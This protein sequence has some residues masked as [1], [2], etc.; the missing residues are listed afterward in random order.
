MN[1]ISKLYLSRAENE[2]IAGKILN[3]VSINPTIQKEQFKIETSFTF[4][5][6]VISHSYY[7][8]FNTA[9]AILINEGIKTDM[10]NVHKKT[11]KAFK[12]F[13]V[14]TGKLDKELFRIYEDMAIKADVLLEIFSSEKGKRGRFTYQILPQANVQPAKE[15]LDN[16]DLFFKAIRK[17]LE[18]AK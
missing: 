13:L 2:L 16:A 18:E 4:Y 17:I 14:Q 3:E 9:K 12:K 1:N 5:S 10:P 6:S 11:L 7:C 15:S 8:I